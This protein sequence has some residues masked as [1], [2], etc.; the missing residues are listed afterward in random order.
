MDILHPDQMRAKG[1][2]VARCPYW[3]QFEP[4]SFLKSKAKQSTWPVIQEWETASLAAGSMRGKATYVEL[5]PAITSSELSRSRLK[6]SRDAYLEAPFPW[7]HYKRG[8]QN[9]RKWRAN[10]QYVHRTKRW[11]GKRRKIGREIFR[12]IQL[13]ERLKR[14]KC[15]NARKK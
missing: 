5:P 6:A 8:M 11:A 12:H 7:K 10:L 15:K 3:S 14:K 9:S 4:F 13:G 1:S 2:T